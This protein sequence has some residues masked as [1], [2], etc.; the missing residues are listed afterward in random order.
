MTLEQF[1]IKL[2]RDGETVLVNLQY[3]QGIQKNYGPVKANTVIL[4]AD[5]VGQDNMMYVEESPEYIW[6]MIRR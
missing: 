1:W 4:F 3:V 5:N 2:N 6:R